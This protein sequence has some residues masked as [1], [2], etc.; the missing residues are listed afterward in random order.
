MNM[1]HDMGIASWRYFKPSC[2]ASSHRPPAYLSS[3]LKVFDYQW[4]RTAQGEAAR[5]LVKGVKTDLGEWCE[6]GVQY[7]LRHVAR[8]R[9]MALSAG[10]DLTSG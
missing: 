9:T 6:A 3:R 10:G 4:R 1:Y 7:A 8:A 2:S 5:E